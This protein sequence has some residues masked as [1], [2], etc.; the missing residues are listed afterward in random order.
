MK[1]VVFGLTVSSSW[2]NGHATLW[3]GGQ[4]LLVLVHEVEHM[5]RGHILRQFIQFRLLGRFHAHLLANLPRHLN[6]SRHLVFGQQA[7]LQAQARLPVRGGHHAILRDENERG[8]KNGFHRSLHG[9]NHQR[10]VKARHAFNPADVDSNPKPIEHHVQ[11]H[12]RQG[13]RKPGD[14]VG[15]LLRP[16]QLRFRLGPL[17]QQGPDIPLHHGRDG[18]RRVWFALLGIH[19]RTSS[20][21]D[22]PYTRVHLGR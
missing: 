1:I 20:P 14:G 4:V 7:D 11:H 12:K 9:Q 10:R 3:R 19:R 2:G 13:A 6:Q 5:F 15:Q 22:W 18:D 17:G 21:V 8:E 16:A